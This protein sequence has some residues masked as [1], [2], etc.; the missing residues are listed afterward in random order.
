MA[1]IQC[2]ECGHTISTQATACPSCGHPQRLNANGQSANALQSPRVWTTALGVLGAWLV[3]P[4]LARLIV[5]LAV[6]VLAYF[7]FTGK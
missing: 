6:C 4:W 5:A 1:L 2:P 7:M 3:T